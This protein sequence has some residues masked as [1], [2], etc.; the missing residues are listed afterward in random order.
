MRRPQYT[1]TLPMQEIEIKL[2]VDSP[3]VARRRLR[4]LG[5]RAVTRRLFE[6][7]LVLDTPEQSLRRSLQLLRLRSAAGRWRLTYKNRPQKSARHKVREEIEIEISDGPRLVRILGR[8]GFRPAFEY[9]KYR[10]EFRPPRGPGKVL[11]DETPI[12]DFLELE[13]PAAWIDRTARELGFGPDDYIL[14]SYSV[15]YLDWCRRR[16]LPPSHMV[17]PE[18]KNLLPANG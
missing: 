15:L 5:F 11:L 1:G 6:R 3:D 7:N 12:G 4:R 18:K 9:Q 16:N 13:G 17:F 2:P 10:T 14:E 8:L